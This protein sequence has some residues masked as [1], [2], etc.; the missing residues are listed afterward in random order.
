M[1]VSRPP[2]VYVND[3]QQSEVPSLEEDENGSDVVVLDDE[4]VPGP[5]RAHVVVMD[6]VVGGQ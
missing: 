2:L 3:E 1:L 5:S 6:H 4:G